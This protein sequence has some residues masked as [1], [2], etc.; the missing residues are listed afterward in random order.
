MFMLVDSIEVFG[1]LRVEF[2][3]GVMGVEYRFSF[4]SWEC[5]VKEFLKLR[6]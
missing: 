1:V 2:V 5:I 3:D 6:E 4:L